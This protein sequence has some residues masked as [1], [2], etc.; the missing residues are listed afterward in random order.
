MVK[1]QKK[2][3]MGLDVLQYYTTKEWDFKNDNFLA[4][5]KRV[6]KEDDEVFYTDIK[7][8]WLLRQ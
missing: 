3:S 1:I 2:V 5:R 8:I 6:S 4:L 7:V